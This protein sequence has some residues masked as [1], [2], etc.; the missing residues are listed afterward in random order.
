VYFAKVSL[1]TDIDMKKKC[2]MKLAGEKILGNLNK[3]AKAI[4][5][6]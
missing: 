3:A 6:H 5:R 1:L 2:I 4:Y